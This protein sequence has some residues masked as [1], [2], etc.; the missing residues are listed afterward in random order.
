M[1]LLA[2]RCMSRDFAEQK[3]ELRKTSVNIANREQRLTISFSRRIAPC[4]RSDFHRRS[5]HRSKPF[6]IDDML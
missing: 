2:F 1:S 6:S 3:L 4:K 5:F